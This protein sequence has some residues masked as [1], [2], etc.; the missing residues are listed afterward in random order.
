ML[1]RENIAEPDIAFKRKR[2]RTPTKMSHFTEIK[3]QIIDIETL[4]LAVQETG[5]SGP[6]EDIT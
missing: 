1:L 6:S 4:R 2:Q 5:L 3:T